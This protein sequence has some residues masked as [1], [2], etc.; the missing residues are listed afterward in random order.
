MMYKV[1][2]QAMKYLCRLYELPIEGRQS[3]KQQSHKIRLK[4]N[5]SCG[6][7]PTVE[8]SSD[9]RALMI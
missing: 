1:P 5:E 9:C 2:S 3:N 8:Y 7:G 4:A 6:E